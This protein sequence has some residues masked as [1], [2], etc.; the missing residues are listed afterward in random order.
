MRTAE[1]ELREA[2]DNSQSLLAMIQHL[3]VAFGGTG[4]T[5]QAWDTEGLTKLIAEQITENRAVLR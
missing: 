2:L 4:I 1:E 3:G 5:S